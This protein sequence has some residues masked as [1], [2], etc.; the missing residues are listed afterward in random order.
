MNKLH[1]GF[2]IASAITVILINLEPIKVAPASPVKQLVLTRRQDV[3]RP[4]DRGVVFVTAYCKPEDRSKYVQETERSREQNNPVSPRRSVIARERV[5][6]VINRYTSEEI[7]RE[8][9]EER[10]YQQALERFGSREEA[11]AVLWIVQ[12]ESSYNPF[13]VNKNCRGLFQILNYTGDL[14]DINGQIRAGL[15]YISERYGNP[16]QAKDFWQNHSWY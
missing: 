16:L 5:G 12:R 11:E 1:F 15:D 4:M 3:I 13:A 10:I 7:T 2:A 6:N 14:G 9:I 8:E